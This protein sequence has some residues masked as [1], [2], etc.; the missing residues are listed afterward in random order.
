MIVKFMSLTAG[1]MS[2]LLALLSIQRPNDPLF[3]F[4]SGSGL[5]AVVRIILI[6]LVIV[7]SFSQLI[8]KSPLFRLLCE[9]LAIG[10][11]SLGLALISITPLGD[12]VFNYLKVLD[13]LFIPLTAAT[14]GL[15]LLTS[16]PEAKA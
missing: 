6:G 4:V 3:W 16:Q 9:L 10:L 14:L 12:F 8:Q 11:A 15:A 13:L 2:L 7:A 5:I 1:T